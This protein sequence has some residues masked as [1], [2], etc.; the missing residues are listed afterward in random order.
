MQ[1]PGSLTPPQSDD[2]ATGSPNSLPT[3]SPFEKETSD[4]EDK[5]SSK[6]KKKKTEHN[7]PNHQTVYPGP[8]P[9]YWAKNQLHSPPNCF[10]TQMLS[11]ES[12]TGSPTP[13]LSAVSLYANIDEN[14]L[15]DQR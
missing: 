4:R 8:Q 11:P 5:K 3:L 6:R 10:S 12:L 14:L 15:D 9:G 1:L 2:A 13:N 7:A